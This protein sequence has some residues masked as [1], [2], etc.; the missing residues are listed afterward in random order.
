MR[1]ISLL[2]LLLA[3]TACSRSPADSGSSG[4]GGGTFVLASTTST[5]DSGLLDALTAEF[6]KDHPW[7]VKVVAVGSGEAL[8]LGR[9]GDADVL[10]VHSPDSEKQFMDEG[11]GVYRKPVMRNDFVIAGPSSDPAGITGGTQAIEAFRRIAETQSL[12]ISRGDESGTHTRELKT[13]KSAAIEPQGEWYSESG[14]GMAETLLI[15]S[16]RGAYVLTDT[17][18]PKVMTGKIGLK[19]L[20]DGDP[21]L[22]NQ[23]SVITLKKARKP[24]AGEALAK[25]IVGPSGQTFIGRFGVERYGAPLFVPNAEP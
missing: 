10:L 7:R 24:E 22:I 21:A 23:Y 14:Q 2:L 25:W 6:E 4:S 17:A 5:Q 9:R 3:L 15:A 11:L 1:K 8:D 19:I 13:W 18:T 12:F 16:E 20:V